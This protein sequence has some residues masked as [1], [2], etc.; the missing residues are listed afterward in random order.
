M[1]D[2]WTQISAVMEGV[3]NVICIFFLCIMFIT[4]SSISIIHYI[5]KETMHVCSNNLS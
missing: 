1:G 5:M 4:H 2:C 3:E